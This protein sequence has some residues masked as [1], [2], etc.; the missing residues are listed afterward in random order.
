MAGLTPTGFEVPTIDEIRSEMADALRAAIDPALDTGPTSVMGQ[1][2]GILSEREHDQWIGQRDVW[3]AFSVHGEGVSLTQLALITGTV[4]REATVS[5][6]T[7]T[8]TLNA[9]VT[10]P[11]G[12]RARAAADLTA[13]FETVADVTNGGGS[14]AALPVVM[15]SADPGPVRANAGTLTVIVTP[16]SGWTAVTNA[17]DA[18]LGLADE[19]DSE[20]RAR[21]EAELRVQGS[22]NLDAVIS[23]VLQ[24]DGVEDVAGEENDTNATVGALSPH[25]FR[26]VFW[27]GDPSAALDTDVAQAIWDS[28]PVGIETIGSSSED[29]VDVNGGLHE[30]SF[31]RATEQETWLEI[32]VEI[33]ASRFP[34]DGDDRIRQ[35]VVDY[36]DANWRIGRDVILSAL[37]GPVFTVSGLIRITAVRAG[38]VINPSG[39][40]DLSVAFDEIARADT[41]RVEVNHV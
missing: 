16:V 24:V 20:L 32:D 1:L 13:V 8:V 2:I 19:T 40:V 12:S 23:D 14:P 25:S 31:D 30:M 7:A 17:E 11:A 4:R 6:V 27:D 37:Y 28:K 26:I 41:S 39:T 36:A 21:R 5:R 38:F 34:A 35:A 9:G 18:Q 33:D 29:A 10:L 22:A 3:Q 15:T